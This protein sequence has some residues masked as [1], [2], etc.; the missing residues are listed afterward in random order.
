MKRGKAAGWM[1]LLLDICII[2]ALFPC[3]LSK[4][5]NTMI[6]TM[7]LP[8]CLGQ[9]C[10]VPTLKSSSTTV[11]KSLLSTIFV[12]TSKVLEHCRSTLARYAKY[13]TTTGNQ[14]GFNKSSAC[15]HAICTLRSITEHYS[16]ACNKLFCN[17]HCTATANILCFRSVKSF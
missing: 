2:D 16:L 17:I 14:F 12:A 13:F 1:L 7:Y 3:V 11:C 8:S 10:T 4:L 9:S 15:M 5:F 6:S